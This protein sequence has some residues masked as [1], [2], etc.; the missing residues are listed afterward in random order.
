MLCWEKAHI[1]MLFVKGVVC[2]KMDVAD[3][4]V[5]SALTLITF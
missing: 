3:E 4:V 2:V 5:H 1:N